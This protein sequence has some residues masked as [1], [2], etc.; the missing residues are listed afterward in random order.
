[1]KLS[2]VYQI[3]NCIRNNTG[4]LGDRAFIMGV[5]AIAL[6]VPAITLDVPAINAGVPPSW[7]LLKMIFDFKMG[8]DRKPPRR[9]RFPPHR[10]RFP[11]L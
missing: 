2:I 4:T 6:G 8:L 11:P 5:P 10:D 1:M 3:F 7:T 9:V